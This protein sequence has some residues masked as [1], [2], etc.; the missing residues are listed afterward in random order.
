[1]S[2]I[3]ANDIHERTE[4][5]FTEED[6]EAARAFVAQTPIEV[7]C[8]TCSHATKIMPHPVDV[9]GEPH[10]QRWQCDCR[11]SYVTIDGEPHATK[12]S[13]LCDCAA[14]NVIAGAPGLPGEGSLNPAASA[15]SDDQLAEAAGRRL[16]DEQLDELVAQRGGTIHK[17]DVGGEIA[18]AGESTGG[19]VQ[20]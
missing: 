2:D 17:I 3:T 1:M 20:S 7:T 18:G 5:S 16:T 11:V 14:P 19:I 4:G 6:A 8:S 13:G 12:Q 10:E 15:I 9:D